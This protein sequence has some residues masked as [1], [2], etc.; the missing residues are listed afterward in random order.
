MVLMM[1]MTSWITKTVMRRDGIVR[2]LSTAVGHE[3]HGDKG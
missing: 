1:W 3:A 2:K